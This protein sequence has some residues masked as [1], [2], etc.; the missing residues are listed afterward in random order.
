MEHNSLVTTGIISA[1]DFRNCP[2]TPVLLVEKNATESHK[3][4]DSAIKLDPPSFVVE[5]PFHHRALSKAF[6]FSGKHKL[7]KKTLTQRLLRI[8]VLRPEQK[9]RNIVPEHRPGT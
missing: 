2:T 5:T 6:A 8:Q 9:R 7:R 1:L 3:E 4:G